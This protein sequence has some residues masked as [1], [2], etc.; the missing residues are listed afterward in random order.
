MT[1]I[2]TQGRVHPDRMG[3]P[4][5]NDAETDQT[6][7]LNLMSEEN[8]AQRV[9][10]EME[11]RGW[12][13]ERMAREMTEA[14]HPLHQ[15]AISKIVN[16]KGGKRRS[17]S[18]DDAIGFAKVFGVPFDELLIP[19]EAAISSELRALITQLADI[20]VQQVTLSEEAAATVAR[21]GR[22]SSTDAAKFDDVSQFVD[23]EI[24]GPA[25]EG[26]RQAAIKWWNELHAAGL[27]PDALDPINPESKGPSCSAE[28]RNAES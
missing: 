28:S 22:L 10:H 8:L 6:T 2:R 7:V 12:S 3:V 23:K 25:T 17:I 19:V 1:G 18:V 11:K 24:V 15:S 20:H 27:L 26:M 9:Q 16:P 4:V 5:A 14:G 21:I 13:Q